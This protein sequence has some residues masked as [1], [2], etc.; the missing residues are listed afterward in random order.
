LFDASG[1]RWANVDSVVSRGETKAW[2][3]DVPGPSRPG[4]SAQQNRRVARRNGAALLLIAIYV[5]DKSSLESAQVAPSMMCGELPVI[6]GFNS[7]NALKSQWALRRP[8]CDFA[9]KRG[10]EHYCPLLTI[11]S[12][13]LSSTGLVDF[14]PPQD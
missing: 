2:L 7:Y 13:K 11:R 14:E 9:R 12:Q 6:L 8:N 1:N 4:N 3:L 5:T 10:G